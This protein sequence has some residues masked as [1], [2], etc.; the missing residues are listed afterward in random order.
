MCPACRNQDKTEIML[1]S[2]TNIPEI[3]P[4]F[5]GRTISI[6]NSHKHLGVTLSLNHKV[7]DSLRNGIIIA[8]PLRNG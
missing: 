2:N 6:T 3:N 8:L 7:F 5:N 1:F 4:T